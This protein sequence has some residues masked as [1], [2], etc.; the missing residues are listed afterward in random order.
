MVGVLELN[1]AMMR[2]LIMQMGVVQTVCRLTMAGLVEVD[3][4]LVKIFARTD[5]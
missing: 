1:H 4:M 2:I 5:Q 3:L